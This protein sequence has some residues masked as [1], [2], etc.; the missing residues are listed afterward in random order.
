VLDGYMLPRY[1]NKQCLCGY[2]LSQFS[3]CR[4]WLINALHVAVSFL[5][6]VKGSIGVW[7]QGLSLARQV[8]YHL[9]HST[10]P[11]LFL[12]MNFSAVYFI[13]QSLQWCW[14]LRSDFVN[15]CIRGSTLFF[16][17]ARI[18]TTLEFL[19]G[20][21]TRGNDNWHPAFTRKWTCCFQKQD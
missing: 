2:L 17:V 1:T 15:W 4:F 6:G 19:V 8:L 13:G 9:G 12:L 7:T 3:L 10:S 21:L 20:L 16:I 11:V 5:L 18:Y 14:D